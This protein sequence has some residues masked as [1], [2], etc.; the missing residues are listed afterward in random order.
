MHH[1][2]WDELSHVYLSGSFGFMSSFTLT[3]QCRY[4]MC[5]Q[6]VMQSSHRSHCLEDP[7]E[8]RVCAT[9]DIRNQCARVHFEPNMNGTTVLVSGLPT[10]RLRWIARLSAAFALGTT[11]GDPDRPQMS[12]GFVQMSFFPSNLFQRQIDRLVQP[13]LSIHS[14][15]DLQEQDVNSCR[16]HF[17]PR[18][19]PQEG[20]LGA[21][22]LFPFSE[23]ITFFCSGR[24]GA[25]SHRATASQ[26]AHSETWT[27][28]PSMFTAQ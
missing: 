23:R 27:T 24:V 25:A 21:G 16:Y 20:A 19:N 12:P 1:G 2:G 4:L 18:P 13:L 15:F 11:R 7:I 17:T 10:V 9:P 8:A 3:S 5:D 26:Q 22:E 6:S 28:G 14:F